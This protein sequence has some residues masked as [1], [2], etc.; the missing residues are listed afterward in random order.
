MTT[1]PQTTTKKMRWSLGSV[2]AVI[3]AAAVMYNLRG[4]NDD[5]G[6][7][8]MG[9]PVSID[10]SAEADGNNTIYSAK[11]T[12]NPPAQNDTIW[13]K[14]FTY[15]A[16]ADSTSAGLV[17]PARVHHT[18]EVQKDSG[19][20]GSTYEFTIPT[21][22]DSATMKSPRALVLVGMEG[23]NEFVWGIFDE[24]VTSE[25]PQRDG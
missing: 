2:I 24:L 1:L 5:I 19:V 22:F 18:G 16:E 8:A 23:S 17:I 13:Y 10:F 9:V 7:E 6:P 14:I 21:D 15:D 3:L 25:E 11:V 4:C 20:S 12:V